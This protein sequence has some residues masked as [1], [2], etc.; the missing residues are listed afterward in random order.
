MR[1]E[2]L[3]KLRHLDVLKSSSALLKLRTSL[4]LCLCFFLAS[5]KS[6][7]TPLIAAAANEQTDCIAPLIE[8][9]VDV[10]HQNFVS[11]RRLDFVEIIPPKKLICF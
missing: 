1:R 2:V 3:L 4:S 11:G 9:G 7:F 8:A 6:C 5:L 10:N